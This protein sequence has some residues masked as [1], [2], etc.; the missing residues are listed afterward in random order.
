MER[1]ALHLSFKLLIKRTTDNA[2]FK[3]TFTDVAVVAVVVVVIVDGGGGVVSHKNLLF[4]I[5]ASHKSVLL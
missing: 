3:F 2:R 1:A 5:E 4:A